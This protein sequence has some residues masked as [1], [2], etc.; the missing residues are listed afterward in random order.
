MIMRIG[1]R[2]FNVMKQ[3]PEDIRDTS[4]LFQIMQN[5]RDPDGGCPRDQEQDFSTIAPCAIE[6]AHEVNDA[7]ERNDLKV[8]R[9]EPGDLLLQVVFHAQ[10]A[11]EQGAFD[12]SDVVQSVCGKM[13]RRHPHVFGEDD[14]S[15]SVARTVNWEDIKARERAGS[16]K[17]RKDVLDGIPGAL[18]ALVRAV[19]LQNRAA[20]VGFDWPDWR[21]VIDR[22]TKKPRNWPKLKNLEIM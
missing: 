22:P 10:M 11:D 12:F 9:D 8:L 7:I 20:R 5:L 2:E 15:D 13:I 16:G 19:K 6:E 1:C 17:E 21:H 18:P 14:I 3:A 4:A